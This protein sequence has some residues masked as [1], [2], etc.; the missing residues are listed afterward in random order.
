MHIISN[1]LNKSKYNSMFTALALLFVLEIILP[2]KAMISTD[3]QLFFDSPNKLVKN[4]DNPFSLSIEVQS[5]FNFEFWFKLDQKTIPEIDDFLGLLSQTNI[6]EG[7]QLFLNFQN[8][9]TFQL[10]AYKHKVLHYDEV[11]WPNFT[12][13]TH[14][15]A[16][17]KLVDTGKDLQVDMKFR[18]NKGSAV[19][20]QQQLVLASH[21]FGDQLMLSLGSV[22]PTDI[23]CAW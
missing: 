17:L 4:Q 16:E 20:L 7:Y 1:N 12:E 19:D 23:R 2:V 15:S 11:S 8:K 13:W 3:K 9:Q 14:L 10:P 22:L 18:F 21:G 5:N 6:N